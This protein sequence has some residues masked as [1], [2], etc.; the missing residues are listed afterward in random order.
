MKI[1]YITLDDSEGMGAISL[2]ESP[3]VEKN[4]LCFNEQKPLK[5]EMQDES[6]HRITGVVA[7]ADTPIY[8]RDDERGEYY[9]IFTK[10]TI[11]AM[12]DKYAKDGLFNSVNLNHNS[13]QFVHQVFMVESYIKDTSRGI[14]PEGFE[15]VSD[16]SWFVTFKVEDE[17]LWKEIISTSHFNGFSLEGIFNLS[18]YKL[19]PTRESKNNKAV[20][21]SFEEFVDNLLKD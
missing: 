11:K 4:F 8:R 20:E 16:G 6:Q 19:T 9:I 14:S 2:V 17:K 1:Y 21:Q 7:L 5:L 15:D 13:E 3:A 12:V 18:R 10:D